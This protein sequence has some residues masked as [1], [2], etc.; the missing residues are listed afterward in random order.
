VLPNIQ[1]LPAGAAD[2]LRAFVRAGGGLVA[3]AETSLYDGL[4]RA[5]PDFELADLLGV[6]YRGQLA[7]ETE[8]PPMLGDMREGT[9]YP[10]RQPLKFIKLGKHP[11]YADDPVIRAARSVYAVPEYRRGMPAD[12]DFVYP[13]AVLKVDVEAGVQSVAWEATQQPARTWPF[14][15]ARSYGKGRVVYIAANL[16]FQYCSHNTWP[17]IRRLLTNAV[18][19]AAGGRLPPCAAQ[20]PLHVQMTVFRQPELKRTIVHLLNDPAP[21]GYPPFTKQEWE[22]HFSSFDRCK[23]EVVPV[24]NLPVRLFGRFA[25][26]YTVPGEAL[27]A[28]IDG[29]YT[30]VTVPRLDT[31]IMVVGEV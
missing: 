15:T 14:I 23:E 26:V 1:S 16:G 4:G 20:G 5:R 19:Y 10:N 28:T 29:D 25:R 18:R 17:H 2:H 11:L 3:L 12:Y 8:L 24:F 13:E 7:D 22:R 9:S 27:P 21:H 30:V 6:H 31:H